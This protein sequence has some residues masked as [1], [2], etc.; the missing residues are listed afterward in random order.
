VPIPKKLANKAAEVLG[1]EATDA[2][3]DWIDKTESNVS[4]LH[5][6]IAEL[7][8]EMETGFVRLA[9]EM[10]VGFAKVDVKFAQAEAKLERQ[11]FEIMKWAFGFWIASLAMLL[12]AMAAFFRLGR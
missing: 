3:S 11:S 5:A 9:E 12:G 6:D 10:R 7:R 2:M 8:H 4:A 1:G